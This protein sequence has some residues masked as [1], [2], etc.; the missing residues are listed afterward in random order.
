M[1]DLERLLEVQ[2]H[3]THAD[4]LRHRRETL[5][6]RAALADAE[7]A[8]AALTTELAAVES[9]RDALARDQ[10]RTEDEIATFDE[11]VTKADRRLYGGTVSNPR[12]LR[13]LQDDI[14]ALKRRRSQL[15]DAVLELMEQIE[16]LQSRVEELRF[17]VDES[18]AAMTAASDALV[19]AEAEVEA[20]LEAVVAA[21]KAAVD[22]VAAALVEEYEKLRKQSGGVAIARLSR[23]RC[24]G[25]HL[26]L[27][28][29]EYDRIRHL[30]ADE[31]AHCE[32][33]G[34]MLVH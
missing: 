26:T 14:A 12:E 22:G 1:S 32:E 10:K 27:S 2:G 24:E 21:R 19:A 6:E 16:P 11:R 31:L 20:E 7:R 9:A 17:R 28:A 30:P 8:H 18:E 3:D 29:V 13:A 34:R 5:P 4:Q 25:C 33:C 15:E 23:D